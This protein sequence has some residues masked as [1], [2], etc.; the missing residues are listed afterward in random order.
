MPG[1]LRIAVLLVPMLGCG[2][3]QVPLGWTLGDAG[4]WRVDAGMDVPTSSG[5]AAGGDAGGVDACWPSCGAIVRLAPQETCVVPIPCGFY[6]DLLDV[7]VDNNLVPHDTS[8]MNGWDYTD[9]TDTSVQLYGDPCVNL[10][11]GT[12]TTLTLEARCPVP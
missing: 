4:D 9:P 6:A 5:D 7:F 10:Q 2:A 8:H 1:T 11:S 12:I 3:A